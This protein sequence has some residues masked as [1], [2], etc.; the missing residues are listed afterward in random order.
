MFAK[1]DE[2]VKLICILTFHKRST[3][4]KPK[5][6]SFRTVSVIDIGVRYFFSNTVELQW[7]EHRWLV[8]HG[9]FELVLE[10]LGKNPIAAD[11]I[12]FGIIR[13]IFFSILNNIMFCVLFRIASMRRF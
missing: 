5:L 11:I 8:Y 12:I 6:S 4:L 9:Y 13:V 7:L 2:Q 1:H 10:S 3:T